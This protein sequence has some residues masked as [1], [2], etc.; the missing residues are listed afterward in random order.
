MTLEETTRLVADSTPFNKLSRSTQSLI[1]VLFATNQAFEKN[2]VQSFQCS[3]E[4]IRSALFAHNL[5]TIPESE[6]KNLTEKL[7]SSTSNCV[8]FMFTQ[9]IIDNLPIL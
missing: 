6:F 3:P 8:N 5:L 9:G 2:G 4:H 1:L 7:V